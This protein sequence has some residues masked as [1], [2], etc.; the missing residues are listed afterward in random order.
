MTEQV[1]IYQEH[2]LLK[3]FII[4]S[5]LLTFILALNNIK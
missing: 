1:I 2:Y 3:K 5:G 4:L